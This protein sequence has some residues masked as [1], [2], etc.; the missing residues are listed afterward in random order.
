MTNASSWGGAKARTDGQLTPQA[1]LLLIIAAIAWVAVVVRSR[2]DGAMDHEMTL[3]L[4]VFLASWILMVAAMMLPSMAPTASEYAR[5]VPDRRKRRLG[6]FT[7]GYLAIWI[8]AG[9]LAL[10][11]EVLVAGPSSISPSVATAVAVVA[12]LVCGLYQFSP[13]KSRFLRACRS[14]MSRPPGDARKRGAMSDFGIGA[15]HGLD[16]LACCWALMVALLALGA[17]SVEPMLVFSAVIITEKVWTTGKT[18]SRLIG[19]ASFAL[20]VG[21]IWIPDLA[22]GLRP[23]M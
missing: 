9:V 13:F 20:A 8:A 18:F 3:A 17:M 4:P 1:A 23:A 15:R 10:G 6:L 12:Y 2:L 11:L 5:S 22:A 19:L 21:A 7:A 14:P 16:C